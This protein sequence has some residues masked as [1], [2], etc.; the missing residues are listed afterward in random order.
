MATNN[1]GKEKENQMEV[2]KFTNTAEYSPSTSMRI[3]KFMQE[4]ARDGG[5][6]TRDTSAQALGELLADKL[7]ILPRS[8]QGAIN[9]LCKKGIVNRYKTEGHRADF[10]INY[11]SPLLPSGFIDGASD[12][13]KEYVAKVYAMA[14]K[15]RTEGA[16]TYVDG[17]GVVVSKGQQE[18]KPEEPAEE[19][20]EAEESEE[21]AE[22][23]AGEPEK[24][25][26]EPEEE[27]KEPEEKPTEADSDEAM[28]LEAVKEILMPVIM[29]RG[30]N[31]RNISLTIN[32]NLNA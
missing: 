10:K 18:E 30:N 12:A 29:K 13:E 32:I 27:P 5:R 7:E 9:A 2:S 16:T 26:E 4:D 6:F 1:K 14:E 21:P 28:A 22:E 15:R 31:G 25:E 19:P 11:F 23:L 3:L 24:D 20:K 8:A 17:S